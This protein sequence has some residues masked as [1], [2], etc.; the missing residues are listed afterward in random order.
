MMDPI[1]AVRLGWIILRYHLQSWLLGTH[2]SSLLLPPNSTR[3]RSKSTSILPIPSWSIPLALFVS[4]AIVLLWTA[5]RLHYRLYVER[6]VSQDGINQF[7]RDREQEQVHQRRKLAQRF[8]LVASCFL[9]S[10]I[11]LLHQQWM[12]NIFRILAPHDV[13]WRNDPF[14][15]E[16][17]LW[18]KQSIR[19]LDPATLA[20]SMRETTTWYGLWRATEP[21]IRMRWAHYLLQSWDRIWIVLWIGDFVMVIAL[22]RA[23]GYS[24]TTLMWEIRLALIAAG[25]FCKN[26]WYTFCRRCCRIWQ[27]IVGVWSPSFAAPVIR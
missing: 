22:A 5:E 15:V 19:W 7:R 9:A 25:V 11:A 10:V 20:Q 8:Q 2:Q 18:Q 1:R 23:V 4:S 6:T 3:I 26:S 14:Q 24:L 17:P 16:I 27:R 21:E 13:I 12:T